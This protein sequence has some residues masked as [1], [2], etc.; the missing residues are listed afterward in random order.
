MA[1]VTICSD[2]GAL[3]SSELFKNFY[4]KLEY[5]MLSVSGIQQST[6][7]SSVIHI[8]ISTLSPYRL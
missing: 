3:Y 6:P 4:F 7:E 2:F 1:A 5:T 8:H